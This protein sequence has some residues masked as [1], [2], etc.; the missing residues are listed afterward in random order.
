MTV[1]NKAINGITADEYSDD[2]KNSKI[3]QRNIADRFTDSV[4]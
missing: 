3:Y 4:H 1:L 2:E